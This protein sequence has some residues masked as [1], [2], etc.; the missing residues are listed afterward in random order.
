M[1]KT[2]N[3]HRNPPPGGNGC[4]QQT[5]PIERGWKNVQKDHLGTTHQTW[6]TDETVRFTRQRFRFSEGTQGTA[7]RREDVRNALARFDQVEEVTDPERDLAFA[8]IKKAAEHYGVDI[9]EKDW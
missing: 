9:R 6:K 4:Y 8:N 3:T 5:F 2:A 7:H 1:F